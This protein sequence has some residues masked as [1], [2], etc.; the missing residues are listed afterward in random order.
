MLL[1]NEASS[2]Q[3]SGAMTRTAQTAS[4]TCAS[5]LKHADLAL[6]VRLAAGG[7]APAVPVRHGRRRP[8][9][10]RALSSSLPSR[11]S[12]IV[13]RRVTRRVSAA[14]VMVRKNS[15]TPIAEA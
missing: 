8:V 4:A 10:G 5:P 1:L 15:A 14:N 12:S 11:H 6:G 7:L 13:S 3:S 2:V 9:A